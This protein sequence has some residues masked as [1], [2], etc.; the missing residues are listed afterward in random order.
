MTIGILQ[1]ACFFGSLQV[2]LI[3]K[4]FLDASTGLSFF[5]LFPHS[6]SAFPFLQ[7]LPSSQDFFA[8][9]QEDQLSDASHPAM[10]Y[11]EF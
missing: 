3:G 9:Q 5:A 4:L 10:S 11:P 7:P 1:P 6:S 8:Q 2:H